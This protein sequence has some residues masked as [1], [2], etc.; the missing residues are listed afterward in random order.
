MRPVSVTSP[1][2]ASESSADWVQWQKD[3]PISGLQESRHTDC[4]S[5]IVQENLNKQETFDAAAYVPVIHRPQYSAVLE[6]F[7]QARKRTG[8]FSS[9]TT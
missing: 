8:A 7:S 4:R 3:Q 2:C 5:E 9:W 1:F 6:R